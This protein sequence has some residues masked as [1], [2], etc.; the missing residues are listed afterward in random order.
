MD[1]PSILNSSVVTGCFIFIN[2]LLVWFD[3][4]AQEA[5]HIMMTVLNW[6]T[7][8]KNKNWIDKNFLKQDL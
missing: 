8:E 3:V 1:F 5:E 7:P 2:P 4:A 6:E